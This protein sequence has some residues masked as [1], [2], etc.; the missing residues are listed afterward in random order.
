MPEGAGPTAGPS[1]AVTR[2]LS[3][4]E[5]PHDPSPG[6]L[7]TVAASG[8]IVNRYPDPACADLILARAHRQGVEPDR[9]TATRLVVIGHPRNP[10]GTLVGPDERRAFLDRTPP[11]CL[12]ALDEAYFEYVD[13]PV[14]TGGLALCDEYPNLVVLR[15]FSKAYGLAGR[16]V[17]YLAVRRRRNRGAPQL[18]TTGAVG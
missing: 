5:S 12:V 13:E 9:L 17:G 18:L 1:H 7:A 2:A 10:T 4:N 6:I 15:T 3:G 8:R 16:R 14:G 11:T